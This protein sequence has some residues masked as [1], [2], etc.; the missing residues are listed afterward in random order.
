MLSFLSPPIIQRGGGRGWSRQ[1]VVKEVGRSRLQG[2][3][4][5]LEV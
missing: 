4:G 3:G 1:M 5:R 2:G